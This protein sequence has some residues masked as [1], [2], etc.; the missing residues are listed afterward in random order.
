MNRLRLV[1]VSSVGLAACTVLPPPPE[2][3]ASAPSYDVWQAR[4]PADV[5]RAFRAAATTLADSGWVAQRSDSAQGIIATHP[6]RRKVGDGEQD[7]RFD[8]A[9]L[10]IT[11][12]SSRIQVRSEWCHVYDGAKRCNVVSAWVQEWSLVRGIGE[13][14]LQQL[15]R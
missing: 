9:V 5:G 6:S 13:G 12:D 15:R 14:I 10:P 2:T 11:A 7:Y 4:V 1:V 8:V 3:G